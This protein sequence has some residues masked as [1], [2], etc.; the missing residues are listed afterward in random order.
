ME[1]D[2]YRNMPQGWTL[3]SARMY[4]EK[5]TV[6][7]ESTMLDEF[8]FPAARDIATARPHVIVFGCTSAGALRGNEYDGWL[9]K[10]ISDRTGIPALSVIKSVKDALD[11]SLASRLVVV[12][13]YV[14][15][16]NASIKASLESDGRIVLRVSGLG[17]SEG[18]EVARVPKERI[19][20]FASQAVGDLHPDALF[21]PCTNFPAMGA[22]D[23]LRRR[24]PFPVVTSN[25]ATLEGAISVASGQAL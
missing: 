23:V 21:I 15:E 2:F 6:E 13:P 9:M 1:P 8:V 7:A 5:S 16:L 22:L 12:T 11:G 3:H 25:Q 10:E 24:F 14:E 18:Y 19:I 20:E 4:L 17:I